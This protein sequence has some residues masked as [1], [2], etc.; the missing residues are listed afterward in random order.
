MGLSNDA[1]QTY[2]FGSA[3]AEQILRELVRLLAGLG[4]DVRDKK[5]LKQGYDELFNIEYHNLPDMTERGY[6]L[7]PNHISDFDALILGAG[8]DNIKIMAKKEW[9]DNEDLMQFLGPNYDLVGID[10]KSKVSQ[11]R[12]MVD[13]IKHLTAPG[14]AAHA[15]IFP[16][17]TISDVNK[18]SVE[19]VQPGVFALAGKAGTPVLPVYIEQPNFTHPTRIVFGSPMPV[20]QRR[21]DCRARWMEAVIGLQNGLVPP[22]RPP[23]LTEKHANNNKPGDPFF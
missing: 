6:I 1:G 7:A 3:E 8:C 17:G 23:V 19:R 4:V 9:V 16:Q 12:A 13:I 20:P 21:E 11:A 10:R 22:A 5:Q 15:L 14:P 18:N 2:S